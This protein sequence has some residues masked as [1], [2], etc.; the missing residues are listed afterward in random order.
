MKP[1]EQ[2]GIQAAAFSAW[3]ANKNV[4]G[5]LRG[6]I[7]H[8]RS[9]KGENVESVQEDGTLAYPFCSR[10]RAAFCRVAKGFAECN[11]LTDSP[12]HAGEKQANVTVSRTKPKVPAYAAFCPPRPVGNNLG[13][14]SN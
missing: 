9:F 7:E 5:I 4:W 14:R 1:E 2:P 3:L 12:G 10:L 13:A 11:N 8:P 6:R